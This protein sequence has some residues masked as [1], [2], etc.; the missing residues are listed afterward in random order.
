MIEA[1]SQITQVAVKVTFEPQA[2]DSLVNV[3]LLEPQLFCMTSRDLSPKM[4]LLI[5][6]L[7]TATK[8]HVL[9]V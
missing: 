9:P 4:V 1:I 7:S 5:P 6:F 3:L 8:A 2:E